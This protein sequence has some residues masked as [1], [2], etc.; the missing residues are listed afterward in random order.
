[1][2]IIPGVLERDW[3]TIEK[4]L[5]TISTF[6]KFAHIDFIDGKFTDAKTYLD[7]APFKRYSKKLFLEAHLMV[8][9]PQEYIEPLARAGFKRFIGHVERMPSQSDFVKHAR[10]WGEVGLAL[11]GP[12]DLD[13]LHIQPNELDCILIFTAD[14]VGSSGQEFDSSRLEKIKKLREQFN[15]SIEVDGGI[16]KDTILKAKNAGATRFVSTGFLFSS[17]DPAFQYKTLLSRI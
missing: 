13:N 14:H 9:N 16:N 1:M 7:P 15:I 5:S 17:K 8:V 6:S 4:R 2:E 3:H 10:K 12:T 11:D